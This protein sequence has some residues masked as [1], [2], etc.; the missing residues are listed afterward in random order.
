M[1]LSELGAIKH[2]TTQPHYDK[3]NGDPRS[4]LDISSCISPLKALTQ[5]FID[6]KLNSS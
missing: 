3:I 1:A 6:T 5:F 2:E 4:E